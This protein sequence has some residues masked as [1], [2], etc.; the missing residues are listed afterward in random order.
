MMAGVAVARRSTEAPHLVRPLRRW[1]TLNRNQAKVGRPSTSLLWLG[2]EDGLLAILVAP[3]GEGIGLLQRAWR[4]VVL[5][6]YCC[7][8][9]SDACPA[10]QSDRLTRSTFRLHLSW[11][12]G[13]VE[14]WESPLI[15]TVRYIEKTGF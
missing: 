5:A 4:C 8:L 3:L 14:V 7:R 2:M 13:T 1:H 6:S 10:I 9:R 12:S 15:R 11:G